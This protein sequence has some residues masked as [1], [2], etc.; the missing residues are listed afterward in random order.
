MNHEILKPAALQQRFVQLARRLKRAFLTSIFLSTL[1]F[2]PVLAHSAT[3]G[4]FTLVQPMKQFRRLQTATLLLDGTVLIVGGVP[5]LPAA[6]S[7]I[8]NPFI[9]NW[10]SSGALNTGREFHT[11][12]LLQDGRVLVAGG[13][14][15]FGNVFP[16]S[17][18]IFDPATGKWSPTLPLASGRTDHIAAL[19]PD[20]KVLLAGGFNT[21]DTGPTT[22]LFDPATAVATPT[23]LA[24]SKEPSGA[25][26]ITFR[27]TPGLSFTVLAATNIA[28]P[29]D[30]WTSA[31][32]AAEISPGRYQFTDAE[33]NN[34]QRFYRT[35]SN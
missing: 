35:R 12:T 8:Y 30:E 11:A 2:T 27:N 15:F 31:G 34:P 9:G 10:T 22:E 32:A 33:A 7:E 3:T 29:V 26:Q 21:S 17:A 28:A 6:R 16:T 14:S 18:E 1:A 25:F 13:A 24:A 5:F 20:G 23:L 19:L 4:S